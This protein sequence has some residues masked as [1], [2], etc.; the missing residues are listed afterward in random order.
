MLLQQTRR[1]SPVQPDDKTRSPV[2]DTLE[3]I[4][5]IRSDKA[6]H[7]GTQKLSHGLIA[8]ATSVKR[9]AELSELR[10]APTTH[11]ESFSSNSEV[12]EPYLCNLLDRNPELINTTLQCSFLACD[13][14]DTL[15]TGVEHIAQRP[16]RDAPL[17]QAH[18]RVKWYEVQSS[19]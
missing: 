11:N 19:R 14:S 18:R 1:Q 9:Y 5:L 2:V 17:Q 6:R 3:G 4:L 8:T 15:F 12:V 13:V 16:P 10:E 7:T